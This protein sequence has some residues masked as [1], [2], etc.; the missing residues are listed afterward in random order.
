MACLICG[1]KNA[2]EEVHKYFDPDKYEAYMGIKDVWRVWWKCG[3]CGHYKQTRN[4]PLADLEEI[5]KH[6]YRDEKFR[7]KTIESAFEEVKN[8]SSSES[9]NIDRCGW[10]YHRTQRNTSVL[11]VGS[12]LGIFPHRLKKFGYEVEC[13]E[14]NELSQDFISKHLGLTCYNSIPDKQY[15]NTSL[16]HVL[17]HIENPDE[18]LKKIRGITKRHLFIEVP[19]ARE[20]AYLDKSHDEFNS[21]H[22][23]FFTLQNL[24]TLIERNGFTVTEAKRMFY[25]Q[26]KLSRIL[27]LASCN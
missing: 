24:I 25:P 27:V 20:F 2:Q 26:R 13:V 7:G 22:L 9:E 15:W 17:E 21:C 23:W 19:D 14:E 1:C 11:D 10:F 5:Y 4:Y 6:G 16:V 12:G 3:N 18:F 8:L